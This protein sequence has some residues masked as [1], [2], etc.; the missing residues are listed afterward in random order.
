MENVCQDCHKRFKSDLK[1]CPYCGGEASPPR[2]VSWNYDAPG[3]IAHDKPTKEEH[4][5]ASRENAF[6][7]L[8]CGI[9]LVPMWLYGLFLVLEELSFD[10]QSTILILAFLY[11]TVILVLVFVAASYAFTA[12]REGV[13]V[14]AAVLVIFHMSFWSPPVF[15]GLGLLSALVLGMG[16]K[17][18]GRFFPTDPN[19]MTV[20]SGIAVLSIVMAYWVFFNSTLS[21]FGL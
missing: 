5:K 20:L 8:C 18:R 3:M 19:Y 4:R 17:G 13:Q 1:F 14:V 12:R 15:L 21:F 6:V 7:L 2:T 10:S 9:L 16:A 11:G